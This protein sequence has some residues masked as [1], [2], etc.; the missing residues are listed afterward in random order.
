MGV[1]TL[2]EDPSLHALAVESALC[3]RWSLPCWYYLKPQSFA[4]NGQDQTFVMCQQN[5][6]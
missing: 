3:L 4:V 2:L 5:L 6:E 1:S